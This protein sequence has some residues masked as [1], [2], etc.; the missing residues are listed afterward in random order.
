MATQTGLT[1]AAPN[2]PYVVSNDIPRPKPGPKQV[3]VKSLF[4]GVNPMFVV[5][6]L[7]AK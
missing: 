1:I 5:K 3:L 2:E 6:I 4:V 7:A